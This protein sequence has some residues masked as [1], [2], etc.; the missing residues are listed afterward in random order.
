[1]STAISNR[2]NDTYKSAS[3]E[4]YFLMWKNFPFSTFD[5]LLPNPYLCAK[6]K[7]T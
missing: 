6:F 5:F 4:Q 1:M 7:A 3:N 2:I